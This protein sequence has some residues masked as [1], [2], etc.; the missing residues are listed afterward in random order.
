MF[1]NNINMRNIKDE[2]AQDKADIKKSWQDILKRIKE[3]LAFVW[4][5][6]VIEDLEVIE[7][8]VKKI[9]HL[10]KH[11]Y[12]GKRI[13]ADVERLLSHI[14]RKDSTKA[15]V[16]EL[17]KELKQVI[18][19]TRT[20]QEEKSTREGM[21]I[22][23]RNRFPI[24]KYSEAA[25]FLA[26]HPEDLLELERFEKKLPGGI[27]SFDLPMLVK[28]GVITKQSCSGIIKNLSKLADATGKYTYVALEQSLPALAEIGVLSDKSCPQILEGLTRIAQATPKGSYVEFQVAIPALAKAGI[29]TERSFADIFKDMACIILADE[30]NTIPLNFFCNRLPPLV[31]SGIINEQS[32]PTIIK[33]LKEV[34]QAMGGKGYSFLS[35]ALEALGEAGITTEQYL[36]T[37]MKY[38]VK[39]AKAIKE[40]NSY[41]VDETLSGLARAGVITEDSFPKIMNEVTKI[42]KVQGMS[43]Y[44][45]LQATIPALA[46]AGIIIEKSYLSVF[47]GLEI[48][49]NATRTS[50]WSIFNTEIP[51]LARNHALTEQSWPILVNIVKVVGDESRWTLERTIPALAEAGIIIEKSWPSLER[52]ARGVGEAQVVFKETIPNLA[53]AGLVTQ[54][55]WDDVADLL[56]KL[57]KRINEASWKMLRN[58]TLP[59]FLAF[60]T[61]ADIG[62]IGEFTVAV[63]N[64]YGVGHDRISKKLEQ[65]RPMVKS[66][67]DLGVLWSYLKKSSF[68]TPELFKKYQNLDDIG[69]KEFL[70]EHVQRFRRIV[71]GKDSDYDE[72]NHPYIL[73]AINSPSLTEGK[74]KQTMGRFGQKAS[75]LPDSIFTPFELD[76]IKDVKELKLKGKLDQK[77]FTYYND[78]IELLINS[79]PREIK[80]EKLLEKKVKWSESILGSEFSFEV[81]WRVKMLEVFSSLGE[82]MKHKLVKITEQDF[83]SFEND[84]FAL[85]EVYN[86]FLELFNDTIKDNVDDLGQHKGKFLKSIHRP[87]SRIDQL[88]K[89]LKKFQ[90]VKGKDDVNITCI[91]SKTPLDLFYGNY[92]ENCTSGAPEE[93]LEPAFTPVRMIQ[94]DEIV[95]CLHFYEV[96]FEGKKILAI[97][98]IEPRSHLVNHVN[99]ETLFRAIIKACTKEAKKHGFDYL[100]LPVNSTMHSN[101][102]KMGSLI[103]EAIREKN[104][105]EIN[106][107][108]PKSLDYDT[109]GLR[110]IW[111]R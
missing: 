38:L 23:K 86:T 11:Y 46:E 85:R 36:P 30:D 48:M 58:E 83:N 12:S 98:G 29:I 34:V 62:T 33:G 55:T 20:V 88:E 77:L 87:L 91:P 111:E 50:A 44:P 45:L 54:Q 26:Y 61:V 5:K 14:K 9:D 95:G 97:L 52:I 73:H 13:H 10:F 94:G 15:W 8:D 103:A 56:C 57:S 22:L 64:K 19:D 66:I 84:L 51:V 3:D 18:D 43:S 78:L 67:D 82:D 49:H 42:A 72:K 71:Q 108:F 53:K 101:R 35:H 76:T 63:V 24:K 1:P 59:Q 99:N 6:E 90:E 17:Y 39:L 80:Y 74:F 100:C 75:E 110:I 2:L 27:L 60:H 104:H 21:E 65:L 79:K 68:I 7:D 92:G 89:E 109:E 81:A 4:S 40:G 107:K 28:I 31:K 105:L 47:N 32:W 37:I 41:S 69:R 106:F 16:R 70:Q 25:N 96:N 102:G 93:L